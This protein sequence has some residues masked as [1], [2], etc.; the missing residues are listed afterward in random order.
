M[1]VLYQLTGPMRTCRNSRTAFACV[2]P[3]RRQRRRFAR[4]SAAREELDPIVL[5][6]ASSPQLGSKSWP[7]RQTPQTMLRALRIQ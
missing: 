4:E 3:T 7:F 2:L 6:Q 5:C 1:P